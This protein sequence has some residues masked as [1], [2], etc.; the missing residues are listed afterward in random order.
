[1]RDYGSVKVSFAGVPERDYDGEVSESLI[2]DRDDLALVT[3]SN[4]PADIKM[5]SVR[6]S[7]AE[8]GEGIGAIGHPKSEAFTWT[9]G[10][11][12][13]IFGK[14]IIH[15]AEL[16]IGSSGGPLLDAC[17][18]MLG[19]NVELREMPPPEA[20]TLILEDTLEVGGSVTLSSSSI[21][22]VMDGW[23]GETAL[24][25][26]WEFK[27]FCSIWDRLCPPCQDPLFIAGEVAII[28]GIIYWLTRMDEP[29]VT[30]PVFGTPPSPPPSN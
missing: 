28:G 21:V 14:Y 29:L 20:D 15:T 13:N 11:I 24:E 3:V 18:R 26:K 6:E 22:S 1:V 30:L 23:L 17:G 19:M 2:S 27:R 10:T 9:Q 8:K 4:P 12:S 7:F 25:E 5:I 16:N